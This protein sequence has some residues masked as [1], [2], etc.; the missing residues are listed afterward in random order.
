MATLGQL[1]QPAL[2]DLTY[3]N[4]RSI[5]GIG[6]DEMN[7][8]RAQAMLASLQGY[9][10][11]AQ[12]A[13]SYGSDGQL[14]GYTLNF[15]PRLLPGASGHATARASRQ[16]PRRRCACRRCRRPTRHPT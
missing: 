13:P 14:L 16:A 5:G 7:S 4:N 10:K 2:A 9:D 1:A 15:D 12:F 11:N 8:P 3:F 6:A